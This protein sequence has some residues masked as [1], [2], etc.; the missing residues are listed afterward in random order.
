MTPEEKLE[1][2]RWQQQMQA[3]LAVGQLASQVMT[4]L[5]A[6]VLSK[7][8][9][10]PQEVLAACE[11]EPEP[12]VNTLSSNN[13]ETPLSVGQS[14]A[15]ALLNEED[16]TLQAA[17]LHQLESTMMKVMYGLLTTCKVFGVGI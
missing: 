12:E 5:D 14:S 17:V 6:P 4:R 11:P 13:P 3:S 9:A 7:L 16:E 15:G 10:Q 2:L 1:K 8:I